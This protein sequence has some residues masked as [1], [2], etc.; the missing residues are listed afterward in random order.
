MRKDTI[1]F[2]LELGPVFHQSSTSITV[3]LLLINNILIQTCLHLQFVLFHTFLFNKNYNI[4]LLC[5]SSWHPNMD[6]HILITACSLLV[7][8]LL[9]FTGGPTAIPR[10]SQCSTNATVCIIISVEWCI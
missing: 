3:L 5:I 8:H 6:I 9:V 1:G 7:E 2:L 4:I 10:S